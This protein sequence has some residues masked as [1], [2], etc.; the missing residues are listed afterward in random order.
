MGMIPQ[1]GLIIDG[2]NGPDT[3]RIDERLDAGAFGLVY[4]AKDTTNNE[5]VAV[6]FP[7]VGV[8]SDQREMVAFTSE[9]EAARQIDHLNVVKVLFIKSDVGGDVPPYLVMEYIRGGSLRK[10]LG[11]FQRQGL[12]LS[13][14]K[15]RLWM[16]HLVDGI[17]AINARMLHRDI[18]PENIL[19]DGDVLKIADFGLSKIVGAATRTRTFKGGQHMLYMAP[20]GWR[21]ERNTIQ[22]DMYAM[23]IVFFEMATLDFPYEVSTLLDQSNLS[24]FK[25]MH[26]FRSPKRMMGLREDIPIGVDQIVQRMLEKRAQDRFS[27]WNCVREALSTA[28][29]KPAQDQK[30]GRGTLVG[31]LLEESSRLHQRVTAEEC[32][33]KRLADI[34]E[35]E[36]RVD[37]WQV[38]QLLVR[39]RESVEAFNQQSELGSIT[40]RDA[41]PPNA[42]RTFV[43]EV[44]S[45]GNITV[46]FLRLDPEVA[47]GRGQVRVF[48]H[49][50]DADGVGFNYILVRQGVAD[51]YGEWQVCRI[52]ISGLADPRKYPSRPGRFGFETEREFRKE[53]RHSDGGMHVYTYQFDKEDSNQILQVALEFMKRRS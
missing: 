50:A 19:V 8:F 17:E 14:E 27:N 41:Y 39:I 11:V 10:R 35:E 47:L 25:D 15:L 30:P 5:L 43:I 4:V 33:Q 3:L 9:I 32:E 24:A 53:I 6:K 2:P 49:V 12:I 13:A 20:E 48:G 18:R 34:R 46:R 31:E 1:V 21:L 45:A 29:S 26:L 22:L 40:T 42:W 28:W 7:Q 51:Q 36:L 52:G 38:D 37:R 16:D 23:G 44:P